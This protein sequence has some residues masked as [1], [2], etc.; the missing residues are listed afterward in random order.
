MAG[1]G[2]NEPTVL[3]KFIKGLPTSLARNC[4]EMDNPNSWD[5]WKESA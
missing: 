2:V 5:E 3:E 4:V 1:Y